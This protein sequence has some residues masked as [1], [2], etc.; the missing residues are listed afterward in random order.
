MPLQKR[1]PSLPWVDDL[2]DALQGSCMF[3][4]LDLRSGYWQISMDPKD[5]HKTA[6]VTPSGLWEFQSMPFCVSNRCATFQRAIEIVLSGVTYEICLCYFDDVIVPSSNL[7]QQCDGL[8]LVLE[9][10][11]KH[12]LRVKATKCTF[13][14]NKYNYLGHVVLAKGVHAD[15]DKIKAVSLLAEPQSV[16]QVRS[17]LGLAGYYRNFIPKFAMLA[18]PLVALTK[19]DT[20]FHW[21][22]EHSESFLLLEDLLCQAPILA[23]PRFDRPFVLQTDASDLGLEAALTQT[24]HD[25]SECVISYVSRPLTDREKGYSA[26]EKEALAVVFATDYYR[27]YLLGRHFTLITDHSALRWLNSVEPKGRLARWVMDLQEY[28]FDIKHP[29]GT[30]NQNADALSHLPQDH[31]LY[32]CATTMTP[33]Y[34]LQQAQLDDPAIGK[35]IEM[36]LSDQPKPPYFVWSKDPAM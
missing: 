35:I 15:P 27:V 6:F 1:C 26:T 30:A 17:F 10:F 13:G 36:K 2:L 8:A 11:C 4:T 9:R 19:K 24:Y 31:T 21:S 3:S 16:E 28:T 5:Q 23:Y 18:A 33:G 12:N 34:N 20:K 7:Q 29:P 22:K 14:A 32:T 25:G